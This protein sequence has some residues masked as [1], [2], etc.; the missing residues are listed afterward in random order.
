MGAG[1]LI[2]GVTLGA[3]LGATAMYQG[4]KH[5]PVYAA[6][7]TQQAYEKRIDQG[8]LDQDERV[9][10]EGLV[11]LGTETQV[12]AMTPQQKVQHY[13]TTLNRS[14]RNLASAVK[15][16]SVP[17]AEGM[18]SPSQ[19]HCRVGFKNGTVYS[20]VIVDN[21]ELPLS[22]SKDGIVHVGDAQYIEKACWSQGKS[23]VDKIIEKLKPRE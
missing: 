18:L 1:K 16:A 8:T 9:A 4:L 19:A 6:G 21:E 7:V 15:E 2:M 13:R 22:K 10:L 14:Y 20:A 17:T 11:S 12:G 23:L 3:A 5:A